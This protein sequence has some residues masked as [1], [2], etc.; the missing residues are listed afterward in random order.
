MVS[1]VFQCGW[2]F[3]CDFRCHII[4]SPLDT[5]FQANG[6]QSEQTAVLTTKFI[7]EAVTVSVYFL[8]CNELAEM[9]RFYPV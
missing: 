2:T 1:V 9:S 3:Q 6:S 5:V 7:C 4:G 8:A